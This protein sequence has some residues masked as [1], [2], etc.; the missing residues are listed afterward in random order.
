MTAD[1][2]PDYGGLVRRVFVAA[3]GAAFGATLALALASF[4]VGAYTAY[5]TALTPGVG[6]ATLV[7]LFLW[8]GPV[9]VE[10]PHAF[11]YGA[12]FAFATAVYILL[13][14]AAARGGESPARAVLGGARTSLGALLSSD[15]V[16]AAVSLG[17][18][19]FVATGID[20]VTV[21]AGGQIGGLTG[22]DATVFL[23]TATAPIVEEVGFRVCI[24]GL[25]ALILSLGTGWRDSLRALWRPSSV[26][27]GR[28]VRA[29][30]V[31]VIAVALV[32]SSVAF[33][34]AHIAAGSG[35][36]PGKL[37]EAAFGGLVLGYVYVRYGLHV[38][39][40]THWGVDFLGT[41]FAFFAEGRY[42]IPWGSDPGYLLQQWVTGDLFLGIGF[43][44]FLLVSYLGARRLIARAQAGESPRM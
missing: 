33:G 23:S 38:A 29:G 1:P 30:K 15:L 17:F 11:P 37:P 43:L 4:V 39:V 27:E 35:W 6:A 10:L 24:I 44:S 22:S 18:L 3:F 9:P 13:F 12:I 16:V 26:Y 20:A 5:F 19:T 32:A 8:A 28:D 2:A 14:V 34:L 31:Y 7:P 42:G 36:Q 25:V 40:L 41:A 21:A